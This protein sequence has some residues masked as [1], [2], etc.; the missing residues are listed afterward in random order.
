MIHVGAFPSDQTGCGYNRIIWPAKSCLA[1]GNLI[2]IKQSPPK[3]ALDPHGNLRGADLGGNFN[4]IVIQRP[5]SYQI[6]Q[7]IDLCH[8]NGVGV[9][10]DMDD[11][12]SKIDLRNPS[13]KVYDP[14]KSHSKNYLHAALACEKADLVTV[15]T[16]ALAEEYGSHGRVRVIKNHVP[17]HY[18]TIPRQENPVPIVTWAGWTL[19]HPG[20]L[21]VTAGAINQAVVEAGGAFMG[22]G[23]LEI[24]RH[25]QVRLK[26]PNF[27][28]GFSQILDYPKDLVKADIGIVPLKKSAFNDGKSW[29]KAMEY[30]SLGIVPVCSPT[31]D[32]LLL[33][34]LGGCII[35]EKPKDWLREVKN[36]I[37]DNDRRAELSKQV[38]EVASDWTYEGNP[39]KWWDAWTS[40]V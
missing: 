2:T 8:D 38:R 31:P 4:L 39:D 6:P 17:A 5:A 12:L 16:E 10:I 29:L 36:L 23:D 32:N 13:H 20:D 37:Q 25:L 40:V 30:A 35:A 14:A 26:A 33:A 21:N 18:L 11:S 24:F 27:H 19:N 34:E 3:I 9:I 28:Q 15:T 1:K 7:L 22:F